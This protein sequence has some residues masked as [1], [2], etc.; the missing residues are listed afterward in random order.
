MLITLAVEFASG[1]KETVVAG[2]PDFIAFEKEFD[3]S[4]A[5]FEQEMTL[6]DFAW[7][8][9]HASKRTK[10]TIELFDEWVQGVASLWPAADGDVIVPL[11]NP[12]PIG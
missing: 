8:G 9:W 3:R 11:E 7:L 12:Q 6:T 10:R 4:V 5:K 1:A 2:F